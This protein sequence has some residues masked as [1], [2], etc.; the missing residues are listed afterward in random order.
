MLPTRDPPENKRHTQTESKKLGKNIPS[1]WAGGKMLG[2]Q[3][4]YHTKYTSKQRP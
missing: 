3:Y 2:Q 1:K 4:L